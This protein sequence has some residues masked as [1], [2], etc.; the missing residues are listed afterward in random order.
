LPNADQHRGLVV[1]PLEADWRRLSS[2]YTLA[3]SGLRLDYEY[4]DEEQYLA[5]PA[6]AAKAEGHFSITCKDGAS[7]YAE[8]FLRLQG[9]KPTD[10]G[11][12]MRR[13]CA[14]ALA[15]IQ[16]AGPAGG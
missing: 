15:K 8:C 11:T 13:A 16:L 10:K 6:P 9:A 7:Y 14:I 2:R 5:P 3:A 1:P 12:L 4:T